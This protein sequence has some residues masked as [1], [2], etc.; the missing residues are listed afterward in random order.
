MQSTKLTRRAM[1]KLTAS[2]TAGTFATSWLA[3]CTPS[4]QPRR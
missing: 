3:A 4:R 2:L 1:L